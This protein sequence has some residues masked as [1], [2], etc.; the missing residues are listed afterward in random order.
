MIAGQKLRVARAEAK[1]LYMAYS[2]ANKA[3]TEVNK[4]MLKI[5]ADLAAEEAK[6]LSEPSFGSSSEVS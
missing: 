3:T 6:L 4:R 2:A 5:R 1:D